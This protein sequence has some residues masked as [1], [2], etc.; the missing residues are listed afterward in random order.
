MF[1]F[2]C[3]VEVEDPLDGVRV[4]VFVVDFVVVGVSLAPP[5][6]PLASKGGLNLGTV[7]D[8]VPE[9]CEKLYWEA[10]ICG[11]RRI[12]RGGRPVRGRWVGA[13]VE[14]GADLVLNFGACAGIWAATA[15]G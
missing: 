9:A 14:G 2:E 7:T 3:K 12:P 5:T 8:F 15:G 1:V 10:C 4:V 11:T 6:A 13:G